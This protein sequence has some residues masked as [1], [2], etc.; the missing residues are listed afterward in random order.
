MFGYV[1]LSSQVK[2]YT[3]VSLLGVIGVLVIV[4]IVQE[5]EHGTELDLVQT[6][7]LLA[8]GSKLDLKSHPRFE[9]WPWKSDN[10]TTAWLHK[11]LCLK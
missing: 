10:L 7:N 6:L 11:L 2:L 4:I 1:F 5:Q 8:T 3:E 9:Q